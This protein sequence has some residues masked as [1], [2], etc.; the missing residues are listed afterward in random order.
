MVGSSCTF[1]S[2]NVNQNLTRRQ[3]SNVQQSLF[4]ETKALKVTIK[5]RTLSNKTE[6]RLRHEKGL[7]QS[8]TDLQALYLSG[9]YCHKTGTRPPSCTLP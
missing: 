2:L 1:V 3:I 4:W 6:S 7:V 9:T 8:N 5:V